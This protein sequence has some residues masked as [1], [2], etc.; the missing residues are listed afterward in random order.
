MTATLATIDAALFT[1]LSPLLTT[2]TDGITDAKPFAC[3]ARFVDD[4]TPE[5]L[6]QIGAQY[7]ACLLRWDAEA[8]DRDI[9]TVS[10]DSEERGVAQWTVFV[11]VSDPRS[12]DD[13]VVGATGVPGA[14]TLAGQVLGVCNALFVTGLWRN[15]RVRY[16]DSRRGLVRGAA[17]Y[18]IELRFEAMR[19][20][21]QATT[22][23]TSV[24]LVDIR[25]DLNLTGTADTP[26]DPFLTF[27]SDT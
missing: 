7:P 13:V 8:S 26:P 19:V 6:G 22:T 11:I 2:A 23:Q 3:V 15:H 14:L 9:N 24:P 21:E 17:L 4:V 1:A 12:P 20:V 18:V 25:G 16:A 27:S 5:S 10:G